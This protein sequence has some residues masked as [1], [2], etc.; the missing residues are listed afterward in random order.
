MVGFGLALRLQNKGW[1]RGREVSDTFQRQDSERIHFAE[2]DSSDS[3]HCYEIVGFFFSLL[4]SSRPFT[5][6]LWENYF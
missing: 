6:S 3:I 5:H 1:L 4:L 2:N